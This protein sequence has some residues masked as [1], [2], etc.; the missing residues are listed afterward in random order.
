MT[1]LGDEN[2][3]NKDP[4]ASKDGATECGQ[5]TTD[6][7]R[8]GVAAS[9]DG[10]TASQAGSSLPREF[11]TFCSLDSEF[12][13]TD[14]TTATS[15]SSFAYVQPGGPITTDSCAQLL[16][17][18]ASCS[19]F[20]RISSTL[21]QMSGISSLSG[22]TFDEPSASVGSHLDG[23]FKVSSEGSGSVTYG[24][25]CRS[26]FTIMDA[27][28]Q[29]SSSSSNHRN[30][31]TSS[32]SSSSSSDDEKQEVVEK[33]NGHAHVVIEPEGFI[34]VS[35]SHLTQCFTHYI[36][37]SSTVD[38]LKQLLHDEEQVIFP[39][40]EFE[41]ALQGTR[42]REP[43]LL[44]DVTQTL[45]A[46]AVTEGS[47]ITVVKSNFEFIVN[48]SRA[49]QAFLRFSKRG[50]WGDLRTR[51]RGVIVGHNEEEMSVY[52]SDGKR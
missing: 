10:S 43:V 16:P 24:N 32:S 34:T 42:H 33:R 41:L 45:N 35:V 48:D 40:R 27:I 15:T 26:M 46:C 36:S 22:S 51:I 17:D 31:S 49:R 52:V 50:R 21:S 37:G 19:S 25:R 8:G 6:G 4:L 9:Q 18:G 12:Y 47:Q 44:D 13:D 14:G 7:A 30:L 11:N 28:G 39:P 20:G 29:T 38:Q 23:L 2:K 3:E 5:F 1:S